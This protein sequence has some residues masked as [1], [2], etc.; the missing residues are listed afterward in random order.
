MNSPS[1]RAPR[2]SPMPG[3]ERWMTAVWVLPK[4]LRHPGFQS[5]HRRLELGLARPRRWPTPRTPRPALWETGPPRTGWVPLPAQP[6]HP[7]SELDEG[8]QRARV[9]LAQH[10]TQLADLAG[11][12]PDQVLVPRASS[13]SAMACSLSLAIGRWLCR[14]VRIR[15]ASGRG[16][17]G[18]GAQLPGGDELA[19]VAADLGQDHLGAGPL[20]TG[21]RHHDRDLVGEGALAVA[22]SAFRRSSRASKLRMCS[23]ISPAIWA[24]GRRSC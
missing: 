13:L 19:D 9:G 2:T 17:G 23:A 5:C 11:S 8:Q 21:Q 10:R 7:V 1:T 20:R 14:S 12:G 16:I 24:L 3:I 18:P 22:M 15:P 4:M 6:V